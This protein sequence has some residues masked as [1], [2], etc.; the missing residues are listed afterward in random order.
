MIFGQGPKA[1]TDAV[2]LDAKDSGDKQPNT[3][4]KFHQ[5]SI[6]TDEGKFANI[7]ESSEEFS[8]DTPDDTEDKMDARKHHGKE[9]R[10]R[11]IDDIEEVLSIIDCSGW[12][13]WLEDY[14]WSLGFSREE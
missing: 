7:T 14:I 12:H 3:E 8:S 5:L 4:T 6:S 9:K 2:E 13:P 10:K 1:K 11:R